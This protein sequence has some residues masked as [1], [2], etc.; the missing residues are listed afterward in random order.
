MLGSEVKNPRGQLQSNGVK[1]PVTVKSL[2]GHLGSYQMVDHP[3]QAGT[4]HAPISLLIWETSVG[5]LRCKYRA[6]FPSLLLSSFLQISD[7]LTPRYCTQGRSPLFTSV[8]RRTR[9]V[10]VCYDGVQVLPHTRAGFFS[11]R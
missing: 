7:L 9:G 8:L 6:C 1:A 3:V 5:A 10:E 4:N 2:S 11:S